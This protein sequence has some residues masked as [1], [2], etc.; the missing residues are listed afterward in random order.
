MC[1]EIR[2]RYNPGDTVEYFCEGVGVV[3]E[4]FDHAGTPFGSHSTLERFTP[5][6]SRR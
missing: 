2:E 3:G 5:G 1:I 6:N 4:H